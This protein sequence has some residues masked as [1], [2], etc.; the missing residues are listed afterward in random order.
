MSHKKRSHPKPGGSRAA[1]REQF[2]APSGRGGATSG[3][4]N[5]TKILVVVIAA[6]VAVAAYVVMGSLD[7][8][9]GAGALTSGRKASA[10]TVSADGGGEVSIPVSDLSGTANFYEYRTAAGKN[11]R[12]FAM[13]SSDGAYRAALDSCDV[14]FAAKKGYRQQG[15]DMVCNKCGNHFPSNDINDVHGGCNPVGLTRAIAGDRLVIKAA[16][17]EKGS[18]YF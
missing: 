7:D 4:G 3:A 11:V 5:T 2:S 18:S 10:A 12:F 14:C 9:P 6:L 8:R 13:R 1:K 17:L 16:D 15:D